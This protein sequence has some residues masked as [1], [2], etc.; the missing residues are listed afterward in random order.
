M[1]A[2]RLKVDNLQFEMNRLDVENQKLRGRN[3]EGSKAADLEAE[4]EHAR[5]D[6]ARLTE[7]RKDMEQAVT[8][9]TEE[10]QQKAQKL[11]EELQRNT[12]EAE[13]QIE[14]LHEQYAREATA[15][16]LER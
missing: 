4:L 6:V 3:P 1:E 8:D 14:A 11:E 12:V 7:R 5:G 15:A 10:A 9:A 16:T 2:L 13:E